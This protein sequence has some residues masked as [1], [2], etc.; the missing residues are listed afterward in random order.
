[1]YSL[2]ATSNSS[3]TRASLRPKSISLRPTPSIK[4][5]LKNSSRSGLTLSDDFL[6]LPPIRTAKNGF[7]EAKLSISFCSPSDNFSRPLSKL[8]LCSVKSCCSFC[9][10]SSC[11]DGV[12]ARVELKAPTPAEPM[13]IDSGCFSCSSEYFSLRAETFSFASAI[14]SVSSILSFKTFLASSPKIPSATFNIISFCCAS[15]NCSRLPIA[16][17]KPFFFNFCRAIS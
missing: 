5:L 6:G 13:A 10:S 14:L 11:S 9:A 2:R 15:M 17:S 3:T 7:E 12:M 1:M 8:A 16:G 4:R